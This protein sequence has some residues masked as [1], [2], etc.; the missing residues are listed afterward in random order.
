MEELEYNEKVINLVERLLPKG[1][2]DR[3]ETDEMFMLYNMRF[4]PSETG[5]SCSGC[6]NR[7]Y[8]RMKEYYYKIKPQA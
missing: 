8:N 7:V 4:K 1:T 5:K 2:A 6:R 3:S